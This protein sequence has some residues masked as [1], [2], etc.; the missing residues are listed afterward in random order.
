MDN[1][2]EIRKLSD[3]QLDERL[4]TVCQLL[5]CESWGNDFE[6]LADAYQLRSELQWERKRRRS[7]LAAQ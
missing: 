3:D 6:A 4:N 1:M 7:P 5:T 2:T